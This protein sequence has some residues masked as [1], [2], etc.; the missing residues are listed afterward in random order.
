MGTESLIVHVNGEY[1]PK[2]QAR[3]SV[4]DF[5]FLVAR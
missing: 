2:D 1:V 3:I 5:G 4:F